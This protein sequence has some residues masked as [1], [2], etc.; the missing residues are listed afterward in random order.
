[1]SKKGFAI[2]IT[3]TILMASFLAFPVSAATPSQSKD[4]VVFILTDNSWGSGFAIGETGK[5][6]QYI[7]TNAHVVGMANTAV[8]VYFSYAANRFNIAE[9]YYFNEKLDIAILKLP[10]PTTERKPLV[11]CPMEKINMDDDFAALGYPGAYTNENVPKFDKSDIS[12]TKGGIVKQS[13][14]DGEDCYL[15]DLQI[16]E[17][18]SGGP[19]VN[20][21]GEVVGI[22]SFYL[23]DKA[24]DVKA[25][26]AIAINEVMRNIDRNTIAY[27]VT[28]EINKKLILFIA[29]GGVALI[30]VVALIIW[31]VMKKKSPK[32]KKA[33]SKVQKPQN[34]ASTAPYTPE[35]AFAIVGIAGLLI[36]KS[37]SINEKVLIGRDSSKCKIAFPIDTKGV[38]GKHCEVYNENN[39]LYLKDLNS[40]YGTFLSNGTKLI[41]NT[42]VKLNIGD[43]FYLGGEENQFEVK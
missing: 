39:S 30:L 9:V 42:P 26:Y 21:K 34:F 20:S 4:S 24:T 19:L 11:L 8:K 41:P 18:N 7:V 32:T 33:V 1:M 28:G 17:G 10:E 23:K 6:I 15:L 22:N 31:L 2:L 14:I 38:S 13:R 16:S 25:N 43:S 29:I 35:K 36:G 27:S 37:F 12:I 5:P 40:T 3:I